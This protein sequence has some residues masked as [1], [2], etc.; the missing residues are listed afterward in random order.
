[1]NQV[2]DQVNEETWGELS[3]QTFICSTW[4]DWQTGETGKY[5]IPLNHIILFHPEQGWIFCI[6]GTLPMDELLEIARNVE[7][8]QTEGLVERS[9]FRNPYDIFDAGQG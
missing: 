7:V 8:E 3:V 1:M 2:P 5:D 9:Q 4:R 6:R